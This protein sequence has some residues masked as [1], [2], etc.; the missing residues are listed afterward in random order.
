MRMQISLSRSAATCGSGAVLA[1]VWIMA[2]ASLMAMAG[3]RAAE[4]AAPL[5]AR[6]FFQNGS[7]LSARLSPSGR[8]LAIATGAK[9]AR[10]MLAVVDL[11][12][13]TTP[14][15]VAHFE[16]SDVHSF[17]WVNDERLVFNL[18]DLQS[19][20]YAQRF[21]PGLFSVRRD[22]GQLREL[23]R[24]R[25]DFV[26]VGQTSARQ[27][28]EYN[29]ELLAVPN[30]G[31]DEV[32]VGEH[33]FDNRGELE[34]INPKRLNVV[35]GRIRDVVGD[36]PEHSTEWLFDPQGE[37]RVAAVHFRGDTE[38]FWRAPNQEAWRSLSKSPS[39]AKRMQP[40][41]VDGSAQLFVTEPSRDGVAVLKRYDFTANR[42][43]EEP[44]VSAPGFDFEGE[45]LTDLGATR[46]LGVRVHTDAESTV[47][48]DSRMKSAQQSAD[49]RFPGRINQLS[50]D[51]CDGDAPVLVFSYSD[52]DP[53]S[54]WILRRAT[55]EWDPVGKVLPDIDPAQMAQLDL[56]RIRARDGLELPVWITLPHK[57]APNVVRSPAPAVVLV[58]GGP[59]VRGGHWGWHADA[60]F[61][62]SRGYVVIEPEFRGSTGYGAKHF[63]SGWKQWG[64]S[65]Q[66]DVADAVRWAQSK[67]L[68]DPK[69]VC[70]AGASYGG[71]ATLMG[72]IR[73]PD[74]Y[75]CGVAWVAVTDPRLL[76]ADTWASDMSK[77]TRD[78]SWPILI[79]D[80]QKDAD[81]LKAA[82]PVDRAA[83][84]RAP[85]LMAFGGA[86]RR[87]PLEHGTRMRAAFRA[88][89]NDPGWVVYN[90]EG[91]G[92][93]KVDNRVDF[94]ER[95]ERF[96]EKHLH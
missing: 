28:L 47:W 72:L 50:C 80:L 61:L 91:H 51:L 24:P 93:L 79:G 63:R 30:T 74:L 23:I 19:A 6:A 56:H 1:L 88:A 4:T 57:P 11:Q 84:I 92:W 96:L 95:V 38:F 85:V 22:G 67:G 41:R 55:G 77:E 15:V 44:L 17:A 42:P 10:V 69:R 37:A 46:A 16:A 71:Y 90:D 48:F 66:D 12:G 14:A 40:V 64:T 36:R 39:T 26:R 21:G 70:I 3:A 35:T 54:Y 32:I 73:Y 78:F 59:F 25:Q 2:F 20:V 33:R 27:P 62:A 31:G 58:H 81:L 34:S 60:Q 45:V 82:T 18:I 94:W 29:H 52:Q 7:I 43:E 49:Q 9:S 83:E 53:G 89:G 86:D 68:V 8:W 13:T 76:Y 65:M 5:P 75:K 87:V